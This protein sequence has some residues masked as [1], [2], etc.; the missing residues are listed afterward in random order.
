MWYNTRQSMS[1]S[2]ENAA[3]L[4][5]A[6]RSLRLRSGPDGVRLPYGELL[7]ALPEGFSAGSLTRS[8]LA[9]FREFGVDVVGGPSGR[10]RRGDAPAPAALLSREEEEKAFRGMREAEGRVRSIF[11]GFAFAPRMY[12]EELGR[13]V[14]GEERFDHI[15]DEGYRG[16]KSS[17][18]ATVAESMDRISAMCAGGTPMEDAGRFLDGLS[19]RQDV[20]EGM[21]GEAEAK[22]YLPYVRMSRVSVRDGEKGEM[23]RLESTFGMPPGDFLSRFSELRGAMSLAR[24]IRNRIMEANQRLVAFVAKRHAGRGIPLQDLVQEG[25]LGLV[26]AI[27]KFREG[28]GHKFSTYA[29]WWIRQAICRAIEN[30]SRTVRIPVHIVELMERMKASEACLSQRLRR[31][32]TDAELAGWM[33]V[34]AWRVDELRRYSQHAVSLDAK[35]GDGDASYGDFIADAK[36]MAPAED[37]DRDLLRERVSE[38]LD[39]LGE[40]ER[41]VISRRFGI[42][43]GIP[44]SL[45][46]IGDML[47][48]TRE[49]VRQI[50][51]SAMESLRDPARVAKLA[52]FAEF[53]GPGDEGDAED[54]D[55]ADDADDS[56][57]IEGIEDIEDIEDIQQE[58]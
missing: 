26:N 54:A 36:A 7:S 22:V 19:F 21:C 31:R 10:V 27:R 2:Q 42:P 5:E 6:L 1:L 23:E 39:G 45:D 53:A 55:D 30:Q 38:V 56:E 58:D 32:P 43:D 16:R 49:R 35:V 33:E 15:V 11:N 52:E 8:V 29:I 14:R 12:M 25:N 17:Y 51:A 46:D 40:R 37:V 50:E 47:G 20:I 41:F 48:V 28:T 4:C 44:M 57:D 3:A 34:P 18:M 24:G 13:L 9:I